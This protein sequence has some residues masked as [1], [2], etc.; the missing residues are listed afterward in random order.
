MTT[1]YV[2]LFIITSLISYILIFTFASPYGFVRYKELKVKIDIQNKEIKKLKS[3]VT[4]LE[5]Y[6]NDLKNGN[7]VLDNALEL[8]YINEGDKVTFFNDKNV[9]K[10]TINSQ[11]IL[12]TQTKDVKVTKIYKTNAFFFGLSLLIG[13][14]ITFIFSVISKIIQNKEANN[15]S[16]DI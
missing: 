10:N 7:F 2:H 16:R 6:K 11:S 3:D 1:K 4:S 8:G 5:K 15:E 9:N 12:E 13:L 14:V